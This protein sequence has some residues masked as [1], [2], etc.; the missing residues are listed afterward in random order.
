M[1]I[2]QPPR[3][4]ASWWGV[5]LHACSTFK[6]ALIINYN[7][8]TSGCAA[9][10]GSEP[11]WRQSCILS[12]LIWDIWKGCMD[13]TVNRC[14]LWVKNEQI[15]WWLLTIACV[16][17]RERGKCAVSVVC[18]HTSHLITRDFAGCS[19]CSQARVFSPCFW[20]PSSKPSRVF[21]SCA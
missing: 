5:K 3:K 11:I 4:Y 20:M 7:L 13:L 8:N 1:I 9:N 2:L 18:I 17:V 19:R 10:H 12:G 14:C 15:H 16:W 6:R 21:V